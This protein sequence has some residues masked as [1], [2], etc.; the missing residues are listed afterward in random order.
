MNDLEQRVK[1]LEIKVKML[2]ETDYSQGTAPSI[3]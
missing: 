2:E 3:A 1:T